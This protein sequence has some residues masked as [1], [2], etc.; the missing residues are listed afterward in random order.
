MFLVVG[1]RSSRFLYSP[2]S[3]SVWRR[4]AQGVRR[5]GLRPRGGV[6][7][8]REHNPLAAVFSLG[9]EVL[10]TRGRRSH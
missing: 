4:G 5:G 2:V 8:I 10:P 1:V 3:V 6:S 9:R 7:D